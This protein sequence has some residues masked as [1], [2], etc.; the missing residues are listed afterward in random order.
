[1]AQKKY[2]SLEPQVSKWTYIIIATVMVI[3]IGLLI[4]LQPSNRDKIFASYDL[5]ANSDFT[6][7]HPFYEVSYRSSLF[8]QGLDKILEQEEVVFLYVGYNGCQSCVA[9]IG[10]IQKYFYGEN[11]DDVVD[12]I[13]YFNAVKNEKDFYALFDNV[14]GITEETPQLVLIVNGKI[15]KT[16]TVQSADNL[17]LIN[18]SVRQFFVDALKEIN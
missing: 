18:S 6:E 7:D 8:N 11:V 13:Y 15:V 17:Q 3:L 2:N 14:T 10:A 1:M 16:F 12:Q 4:G 9:H 5:V